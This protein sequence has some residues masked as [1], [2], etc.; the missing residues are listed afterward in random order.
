MSAE[1]PPSVAF[2]LDEFR[3]KDLLLP[4][5]RRRL[6]DISFLRDFGDQC[7][8]GI[9][10]FQYADQLRLQADFSIYAGGGLNPLSRLGTC[11]SPGCRIAFAHHF[12]RPLHASM[13]IAW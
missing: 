8:A 5:V 4:E 12:A 9:Q 6:N 13:P 3:A 7:L 10:T 2:I 11:T 1:L